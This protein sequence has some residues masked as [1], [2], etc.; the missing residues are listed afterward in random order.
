MSLGKNTLLNLSSAIIPMFVTLLTVPPFLD[1]IGLERYGIL[2]IIWVLLGYF[3]FMDFGFGRAVAQRMAKMKNATEEE[4]SRLL[5]TALSAIFLL[6]IVAAF[7]LGVSSDY[8]L[9]HI[10]DVSNENYVEISKSIF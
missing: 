1:M 4:R 5:W 10:I 8:I 7:I 3:G 9:P 2:A 6:G